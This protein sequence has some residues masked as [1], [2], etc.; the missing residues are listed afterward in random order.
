[1][2]AM[3]VNWYDACSAAGAF[4]ISGLRGF[5]STITVRLALQLG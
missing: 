5:G 4:A 1:M 2:V 3:R